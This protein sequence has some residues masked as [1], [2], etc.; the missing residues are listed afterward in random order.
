[1]DRLTHRE[2]NGEARK[3]RRSNKDRIRIR[4]PKKTRSIAEAAEEARKEM[5]K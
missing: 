3:L 1:M 4:R 2:E 5:G